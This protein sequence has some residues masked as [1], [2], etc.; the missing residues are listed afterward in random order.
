M[1]TMA[2]NGQ[3]TQKRRPS[4]DDDDDE[5]MP[6][7][8]R[9]RTD[10][11]PHPVDQSIPDFRNLL[12]AQ[13][14]EHAPSKD[15]KTTA[16]GDGRLPTMEEQARSGLRR[17]IALVLKEVGFDSTSEPALERLTEM[18]EE[19]LTELTQEVRL[20]AL[21]SR[22]TQP[23]PT[24]YEISL[25]RFN[26]G[27]SLLRPHLRHPIA[28]KKK[29]HLLE[30]TFAT[31]AAAA[32][33]GPLDG[34]P[35]LGEELSGK[36]EKES[37]SY[38]PA[39]F[40]DF[41]SIHTYKSTPQDVDEVTVRGTGLR[42]PNGEP[43]KD[44]LAPEEPYAGEAPP[45]A[46][47]RRMREASARESK[48]AEEA[49]RGVVRA[50]KINTLKEARLAAQRSRMSRNRYDFWEES[51]RDLVEDACG[52]RKK[53]GD[54][55]GGNDGDGD[56]FTFAVAA[57]ARGSTAARSEIADH[58]MIVNAHKVGHRQEVSRGGKRAA[59]DTVTK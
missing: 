41:P 14:N 28:K 35:L 42:L 3:Q 15:T 20:F 27:T 22:R 18:T 37:K 34:L 58:S 32:T 46:D 25:K 52:S 2:I 59:K 49:L 50:S 31:P 13:E 57:P 44:T 54:D 10:S 21:A 4:F 12:Q 55:G 16:I 11:S 51:M 36:A 47:P 48:L 45:R 17:S 56:G 5:D 24:D 40:P 39:S 29:R 26:L 43:I 30:P 23:I 1:A 6:M 33:D 9:A 19:Y 38:I 8:K 7:A 53:S